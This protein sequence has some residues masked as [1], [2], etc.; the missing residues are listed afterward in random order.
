VSEKG[1]LV[2]MKKYLLMCKNHRFCKEDQK[3]SPHAKT[4]RSQNKNHEPSLKINLS[5]DWIKKANPFVLC[6][7]RGKEVL[8]S[9]SDCHFH[10]WL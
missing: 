1:M 2:Y 7:L 8:F 3:I 9:E 6:D 10:P 4:Q 5:P